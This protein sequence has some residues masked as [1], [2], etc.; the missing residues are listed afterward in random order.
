MSN[1]QARI[2][3]KKRQREGEETFV[4]AKPTK[5]ALAPV[6]IITMQDGVRVMPHESGRELA[7]R[8]FLYE[9]QSSG[10]KS[11]TRMVARS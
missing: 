5:R 3:R 1:R 11:A 6:E 4:H 2:A 9:Q 7:R 8:R 10:R